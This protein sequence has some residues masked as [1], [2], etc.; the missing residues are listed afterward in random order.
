MSEGGVWYRQPASLKW[1]PYLGYASPL[2][3][4]E[5]VFIEDISERIRPF[6]NGVLDGRVKNRF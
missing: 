2:E 5:K 6:S 1:N 4:G 3:F